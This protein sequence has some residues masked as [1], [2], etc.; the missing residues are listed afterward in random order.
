LIGKGEFLSTQT[1][2][3]ATATDL[4]DAVC[5]SCSSRD[6]TVFYEM[7]SVPVNSCLLLDDQASAQ[8]YPTG[9]IALAFCRQCG[10]IGNT[11]FNP[12]MARYTEGYEEQQ[13]FSPRFN[14]FSLDL[15]QRLIDRHDLR[16][17]TVLEIGCGKGDFLISLCEAGPNFG[18]GI[19]PTYAA[20]RYDGPAADRITFIRDFY[21]ERYGH[22]KADLVCCRH[23]LEHIADTE[24]FMR[25]VRDAI[26]ENTGTMMFFELPDVMRVLQESAFWDIYYEHCSYFSLGSL[27][28]LFRRTGFEVL[29]LATAYDGQY[30][31]LEAR[32]ATGVTAPS[33]PEENDLQELADAVARFRQNHENHVSTWR[34]RIQS[35]RDQG[36]RAAIWGSGSKCVAFLSTLG[37]TDEIDVVVDINPYRQG[38]YLP[39]SGKAIVSPAALKDYRP[40][41][42][43]AMNPIYLEEIRNDLRSMGLDPE[44]TA[45]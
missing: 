41:V 2:P 38:K 37:I 42:V 21:S 10:F 9:Q 18:V 8:R 1:Q 45:V 6:L 23:T 35:F 19:D 30:L 12:E 40:D 13:S 17:K 34:K 22:H 32:P 43:I 7:K 31:L 36:K 4:A 28:R 39:S 26:G 29:D 15:T 20:G 3:I 5:K 25:T 33:L 14:A 16:N 44:L 27:A 24:S 11:L